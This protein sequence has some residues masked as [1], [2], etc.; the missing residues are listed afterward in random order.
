VICRHLDWLTNFSINLFDRKKINNFIVS[1]GIGYSAELFARYRLTN[2][3][4]LSLG[5]KLQNYFVKIRNSIT[6]NRQKMSLS[7]P[8]IRATFE[9]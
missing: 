6:E 9:F 3:D 5:Y 1:N 7:S 2:H 4:W 8:E